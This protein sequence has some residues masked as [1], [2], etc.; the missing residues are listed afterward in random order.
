ML[1]CE[2]LASPGVLSKQ[3]SHYAQDLQTI[4]QSAAQII[5]RMAAVQ[6]PPALPASS[7]LPLPAI[8]ISDLASELRHLQPLLAAIA[9]PS[10]RLSIAT[11]PCAG[12]TALALEDLTRILV[13]LVRNS[14][15]AMPAGGHIRIAAQ[16]GN[17][18]AHIPRTLA[19]T[20]TDDGP[21]IPEVLRDEVFDLGFTTRRDHAKADW[22]APRR[23]GLG[24]SIVRNLVEAAGGTVRVISAPMRGARFEI[25]L[26]L[27]ETITSGTCSVP[28]NSAFAVTGAPRTA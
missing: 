19:L 8:P 22:P 10:V 23:R 21:G 14:A 24:L 11:M 5:E 12:R 13:N 27:A 20:I 16:Y 9:G 17:T 18:S 15:D 28:P 1:Y 6:H 4:V 25:T 26:P 3:H 2:L 7:S